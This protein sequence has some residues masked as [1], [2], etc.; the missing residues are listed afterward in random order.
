MKIGILGG[1]QLGRMLALAG[2]PLG[3]QFR[4][5]DPRP[6]AC[7]GQV[8]ELLSG[9]LADPNLLDRF[10]EGLDAVTF[11]WENVGVSSANYLAARLSFWPQTKALEMSQDRLSEKQL[12]NRLGI[13][14]APY[15]AVDTP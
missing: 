8:A 9:N 13:E 4:L 11:E 6:E 7:G 14:T 10:A 3:M 1:G 2:Y 15:Y 12:F 5:L